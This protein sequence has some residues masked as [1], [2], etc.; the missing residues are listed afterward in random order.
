VGIE[1]MT[2]SFE[3][4][5]SPMGANTQF[6]GLVASS[7]RLGARG[8]GTRMQIAC[9]ARQP[10]NARDTTTQKSAAHRTLDNHAGR[11]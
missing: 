9:H 5:A 10:R 1:E 3:H 6:S 2:L 7:N 4:A 11:R 8:I